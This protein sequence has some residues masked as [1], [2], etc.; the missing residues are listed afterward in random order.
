MGDVRTCGDIACTP[1]ST[2]C[3]GT[4]IGDVDWQVTDIKVD[5]FKIDDSSVSV[6]VWIL[7]MFVFTTSVN[8]SQVCRSLVILISV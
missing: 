3:V 1:D 7:W 4:P 5:K 8:D 6:N 2:L